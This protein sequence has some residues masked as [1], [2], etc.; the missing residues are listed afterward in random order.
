[1]FSAGGKS[2]VSQGYFVN[3]SLRF[4]ASASAYLNRTPASA[5]NQQIFTWSGWVKIGY[6]SIG[7]L[8]AADGNSGNRMT[9]WYMRGVGGSGV[10][11]FSL[12]CDVSG[13][14]SRGPRQPV[15]L[16]VVS[17]PAV[18]HAGA[19][20]THVSLR[21]VP[22]KRRCEPAVAPLRTLERQYAYGA[23]LS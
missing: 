1:M 12:V 9:S 11:V 15:D 19:R 23:I 8:Q 20:R 3:N 6:F 2:A 5:G 4:R 10:R 17:R 22:R 13:A 18:F 16:R 21:P 7:Y 14:L